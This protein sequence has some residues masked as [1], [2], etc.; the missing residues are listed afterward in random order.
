MN[1]LLDALTSPTEDHNPFDGF[2][3]KKI[4]KTVTIDAKVLNIRIDRSTID[5]LIRDYVIMHT[6]LELKLDRSANRNKIEIDLE[7]LLNGSGE[8]L[9]AVDV[10]VTVLP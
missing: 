2:A 5:M 10:N 3:P 1:K 8:E 7:Y 9:N 4:T 6:C